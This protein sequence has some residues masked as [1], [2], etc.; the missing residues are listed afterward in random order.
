MLAIKVVLEFP[1]KE[2]LSKKVNLES[3]YLI[4]FYL[5]AFWSESPLITD[6]KTDNDL[7]ILQPSLNLSPYAPVYFYLSLPAKSIKLNL[8]KK[9]FL[10]SPSTLHYYKNMVKIEWDLDD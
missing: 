10:T 9:K 6:P 5:S 3:L 2:F 1:P 4:C 7:L 8:E